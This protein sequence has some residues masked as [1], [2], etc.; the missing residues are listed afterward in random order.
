[1]PPTKD[2]GEEVHQ[3][4]L[5]GDPT[6]PS[7]VILTYLEPL[8]GR[9]RQRFPDVKDE[10]IIRDAVTDALFQ[11]VQSPGRFN[12]AKSSLASYLTMA[13]RGDLLNAL[14]RERRRAARQVPLET[15]AEAALARNTLEESED[16]SDSMAA[17]PLMQAIPQ[18]VSDPTDRELLEMILT[19]E[20]KT[21][22]YAQALGIADRS[23]TEQR[24]I[25]K[26]HK[27]RLKKRL[28]RLGVKLREQK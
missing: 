6:A 7:E 19:G 28:R 4:L 22:R 8:I 12:P 11:Y 3:R 23:E 5:Q 16:S 21:A 15:V 18:E 14:A 2:F 9:L 1:M 17:S 26:R 24:K 20:R 10:T 25:V 27:D 13:A